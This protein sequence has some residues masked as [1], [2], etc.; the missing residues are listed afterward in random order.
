VTQSTN[1]HPAEWVNQQIG[2]LRTRHKTFPTFRGSEASDVEGA[3][4]V[5]KF[6]KPLTV[7]QRNQLEA[8]GMEVIVTLED[9]VHVKL[10]ANVTAFD[11]TATDAPD[12]VKAQRPDEDIIRDKFGGARIKLAKPRKNMGDLPAIMPDPEEDG[13]YLV[14]LASALPEDFNYATALRAHGIP[15]VET[16]EPLLLRVWLTASNSPAD[17][18]A[19]IIPDSV[20]EGLIDLL[21]RGVSLHHPDDA[22]AR[23]LA[24][25]DLHLSG[26]TTAEQ[27][28]GT[29]NA[30]YV[31]AREQALAEFEAGRRP[32]TRDAVLVASLALRLRDVWMRLSLPQPTQIT[33]HPTPTNSLEK[34]TV[35]IRFVGE[36]LTAKA[37][38]L[39]SAAGV[40]VQE[41][42]V[43]AAVADSGE[44]KREWERRAIVRLYPDA[45]HTAFNALEEAYAG[46]LS[47]EAAAGHETAMAFNWWLERRVFPETPIPEFVIEGLKAIMNVTS[48]LLKG[49][50][51]ESLETLRATGYDD[52]ATWLADNPDQYD[53]AVDRAFETMFAAPV[54]S[55]IEL[56]DENAAT[57]DVLD[58]AEVQNPEVVALQAQ[59]ARLS[60]DL[61]EAQ[62]RGELWEA[63][64]RVAQGQ[65][66]PLSEAITERNSA[67]DT[68]TMELRRE[69]ALVNHLMVTNGVQG[70][71]LRE[72]SRT[73]EN[74]EDA[75][76]FMPVCTAQGITPVTALKAIRTE[77]WNRGSEHVVMQPDGVPVIV[78]RLWRVKANEQGQ[79]KQDGAA[80]AKVVATITPVE[81]GGDSVVLPSVARMDEGNASLV[82]AIKRSLQGETLTETELALLMGTAS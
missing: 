14:R 82:E 19:E 22:P 29:D 52:V 71:M 24:Q 32:K 69:Q 26:H 34:M 33:V 61:A 8:T 6:V 17:V 5:L 2:M 36:K 37:I 35:A 7:P 54:S 77:G 28:L 1:M 4:R 64:A 58:T 79:G 68:L 18:A 80:A 42:Q 41:D 81:D 10:P 57:G 78:M 20:I 49:H 47:E 74:I 75:T 53:T 72:V 76:Y 3:D 62:R 30:R 43:F 23:P 63:T 51:S 70:G 38:N 67:I 48:N 27:W 31:A 56:P 13:A 65:I 55:V 9:G 45:F 60:F 15:R 40:T 50:F 11:E 59:V 39:L 16:V 73:N 66:A 12:H 21:N 25:R 44:P 46:Y